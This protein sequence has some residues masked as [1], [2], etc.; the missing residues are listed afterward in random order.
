[1]KIKPRFSLALLLLFCTV[2]ACSIAGVVWLQTN[3]IIRSPVSGTLVAR[4]GE[5]YPTNRWFHLPLFDASVFYDDDFT[6]RTGTTVLETRQG[7]F[8]ATVSLW[9]YAG[10]SAESFRVEL[11]VQMGEPIK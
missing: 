10:S 3:T 8:S 5:R 2:V 7:K 4:D 6:P 11:L 1:M 9:R